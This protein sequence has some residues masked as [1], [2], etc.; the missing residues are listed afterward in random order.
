MNQHMHEHTHF[1]RRT[2][3]PR[4]THIH[5]HEPMDT[6][7]FSTHTALH[8]PGDVHEAGLN[9]WHGEEEDKKFMLCKRVNEHHQLVCYHT[10]LVHGAAGCHYCGC[11]TFLTYSEASP[12]AADEHRHPKWVT[13]GTHWGIPHIPGRPHTHRHRVGH[14]EGGCTMGE[15]QQDKATAQSRLLSAVHE[16]AVAMQRRDVLYAILEDR[17]AEVAA[18]LAAKDAAYV[19]Y[20]EAEADT[21]AARAA[22]KGAREALTTHELAELKGG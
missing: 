6:W 2:G 1:D 10:R 11:H 14:H 5:Q 17:K 4:V 16:H 22:I 13:D 9:H 15:Q 12:P 19:T 8:E 20:R 21:R 18:A 3:N 7:V